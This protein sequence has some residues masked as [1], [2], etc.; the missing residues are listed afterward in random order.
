MLKKILSVLLVFLLTGCSINNI[1]VNLFVNSIGFDYDEE[2]TVYFYASSSFDRVINEKQQN[3]VKPQIGKAKGQNIVDCITQLETTMYEKINYEHIRSGLVTES[4]LKKNKLEEAM[5]YL[6]NK[7][8]LSID[9]CMFVTD[10]IDEVYNV[11]SI[12]EVSQDNALF[13]NPSLNTTMYEN[14]SYT[15]FVSSFYEEYRSVKIPC[16]SIIEDIWKYGDNNKALTIKG[17]YFFNKNEIIFVEDEMF[18]FIYNFHNKKMYI[19]G[20]ILKLVSYE[21]K[22]NT[23]KNGVLIEVH[24]NMVIIVNRENLSDDE[25]L[26]ILNK[27][28]ESILNKIIQYNKEVD[29]L[30][31]RDYLYRR[32]RSIDN[33]Q[34]EVKISIQK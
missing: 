10:N 17:F 29:V 34:Y 23:L 20:L 15:D 16:L 25:S 13:L 31:V 11:K 5:L 18:H 14:L 27:E 21:L 33:I 6:G 12:D 8:R 7:H 22:L 19:D 30:N 9:F 4:F 3:N 2:Y 24:T 28:L 1:G 32:N 26:E